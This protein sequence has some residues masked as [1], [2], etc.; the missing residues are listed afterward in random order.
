MPT[1]YEETVLHKFADELYRQARWIVL[2]CALRWVVIGVIVGAAGAYIALV[3]NGLFIHVAGV[4]P[5]DIAIVAAICAII[6][7]ITG[8]ARGSE[9]AFQLKLEAQRVLCQ[10]QIERNTRRTSE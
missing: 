8:I 9:R 2:G 3:V 1:Q 10:M 6:G 5:S 7:L 4:S